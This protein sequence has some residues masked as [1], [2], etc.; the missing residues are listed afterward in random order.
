MSYKIKI[1]N[2][3]D[4]SIKAF[5]RMPKPEGEKKYAP[6]IE[7]QIQPRAL[8]NDVIFPD[9]NHY[10]EWK[11][12]NEH[13]FT[14]GYL[15]EDDK[16]TEK[17]LQGKSDEIIKADNAIAKNKTDKMVDNLQ[18]AADNVNATIKFEEEQMGKKSK[19][20]SKKRK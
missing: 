3:L 5:Y 1:T 20:D 9:E 13:L 4:A 15:L 10:K 2:I 18:E 14:K 12:Q 19:N 17:E 16:V 8:L 6:V 11:R 7:V